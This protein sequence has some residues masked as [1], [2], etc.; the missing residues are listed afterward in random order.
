MSRGRYLPNSQFWILYKIDLSYTVHVCT[1][2]LL[3][4]KGVRLFL[5]DRRVSSYSRNTILFSIY[6]LQS[7]DFE[8]CKALNTFGADK[9][10]TYIYS[11][12]CHC[13]GLSRRYKKEVETRALEQKQQDYGSDDFIE[14]K[15]G[16]EGKSIKFVT[17]I[18]IH[19]SSE[20]TCNGNRVSGA[21][22]FK[23]SRLQGLQNYQ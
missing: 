11:A 18:C 22:K 10:Y 15:K 9:T 12:I 4:V 16:G 1:E 8:V 20:C 2:R 21:A 6:T 17:V 5:W 23:L 19:W 3:N 13:W 14:R 7:R